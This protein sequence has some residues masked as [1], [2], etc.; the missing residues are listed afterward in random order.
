[1]LFYQMIYYHP[2]AAE[3]FVKQK[4][5]SGYLDILGATSALPLMQFGLRY[6]GKLLAMRPPAKKEKKDPDVKALTNYII[7]IHLFIKIHMIYK[8]LIED[9]PGGA[10]S[11]LVA[12]YHIV[13]TSPNC[14]KWLKDISKSPEFKDGLNRMRELTA[15]LD[16]T[17]IM[18]S[19]KVCFAR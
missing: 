13:L 18:A 9:A 4:F 17:T 1:M 10:F 2:G 5:I 12:F 19:K 16:I 6:L 11:E 15:C 7:S 8:K 3:L 14:S